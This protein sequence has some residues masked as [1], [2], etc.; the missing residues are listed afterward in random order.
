MRCQV[1][2]HGRGGADL[3]RRRRLPGEAGGERSSSRSRWSTEGRRYGKAVFQCPFEWS[4]QRAVRS[5]T[6]TA[7]Q[8]EE[9]FQCPFWWSPQRADCGMLR[10]QGYHIFIK[11]QTCYLHPGAALQVVG[12]KRA[13]LER[14][15]REG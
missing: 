4:S 8:G 2:R 7:G 1:A 3:Q 13:E 9:A 5:H 11:G 12:P 14:E 10:S 15:E 6:R